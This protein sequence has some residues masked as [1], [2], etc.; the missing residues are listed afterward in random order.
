MSPSVSEQLV[1]ARMLAAMLQ[2]MNQSLEVE[3]VL[4]LVASHSA[5]LLGA[6]AARVMM[7]DDDVL[8]LARSVHAEGRSRSLLRGRGG[9][10]GANG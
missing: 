8:V 10:A 7:L 3:R 9:P 6:A 4:Q 1:K 2:S 5:A